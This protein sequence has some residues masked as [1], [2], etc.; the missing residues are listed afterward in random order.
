MLAISTLSLWLAVGTSAPIESH[1]RSS[2]S[3]LMAVI[4]WGRATSPTFASL[5]DELDSQAVIVYVEPFTR[6]RP[7]LDGAT[8]HTIFSHGGLRYLWIGVNPQRTRERLVALIA[9]ELQHALEIARAPEVVTEAATDRLFERI[10]FK[11]GRACQETKE[12][13]DVEERVLDEVSA[14]R[15]KIRAPTLSK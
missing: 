9:H 1:V 3:S 4:D 7:G 8:M 5:V 10:G 2:L 6:P 15:K 11:C 14:S 13:R 12:A